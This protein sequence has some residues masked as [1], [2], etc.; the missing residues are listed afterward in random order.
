MV[1]PGLKRLK[2]AQRTKV[3]LNLAGTSKN[4]G[5]SVMFRYKENRRGVVYSEDGNSQG[6]TTP[7][8]TF[9]PTY[10]QGEKQADRCCENNKKKVWGKRS[11]GK[12]IGVTYPT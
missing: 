2:E 11:N 10:T 1:R 9:E 3:Q 4:L 6:Y 7:S 12:L 8:K 5:R